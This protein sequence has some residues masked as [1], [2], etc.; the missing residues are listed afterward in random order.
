[1]YLHFRDMTV[2]FLLLSAACYIVSLPVD[3]GL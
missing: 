3:F 2:S 1:V